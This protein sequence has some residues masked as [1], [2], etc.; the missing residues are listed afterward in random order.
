MVSN[1]PNSCELIATER[2][3]ASLMQLLYLEAL[4]TKSEQMLNASRRQEATM[5]GQ[6]EGFFSPRMRLFQSKLT[7][8]DERLCCY[9]SFE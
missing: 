9:L 6:H 4:A 5:A 1:S 2:L 3:S 7:Y 8:D